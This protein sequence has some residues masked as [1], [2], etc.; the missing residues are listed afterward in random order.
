MESYKTREQIYSTLLSI[1]QVD[2]C[3]ED[4]FLMGYYIREA[5]KALPKQDRK[6]FEQRMMSRLSLADIAEDGDVQKLIVSMSDSFD[7]IKR[8]LES[9]KISGL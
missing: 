8:Y 3:P 2:T 1:D 7:H 6:I 4:I 5:V 9:N